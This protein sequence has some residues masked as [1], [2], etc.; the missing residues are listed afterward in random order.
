MESSLNNIDV[1]TYSS[2]CY[3][4]NESAIKLLV[5]GITCHS[6]ESVIRH[7]LSQVEG[8]KNIEVPF[9][10]SRLFLLRIFFFIWGTVYFILCS[11]VS[12][13]T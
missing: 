13:Y 8:I 5:D 3:Q 12:F 7:S 2:D 6:C 11:L 10:F 1:N 4:Q 9:S